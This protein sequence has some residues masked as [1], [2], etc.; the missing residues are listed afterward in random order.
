MK[1]GIIV[2]AIVESSIQ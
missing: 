1:E 2:G